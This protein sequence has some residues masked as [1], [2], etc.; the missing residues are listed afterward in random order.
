M[1]AITTWVLTLIISVIVLS[2]CKK[3]DI[4]YGNQ[5]TLQKIQHKWIFDKQI[6]VGTGTGNQYRDTTKGLTG[7]Y[8]D[9]RTDNKLYR[10]VSNY[11]D[12][13]YYTLAGDTQII[14]S[15]NYSVPDT[16]SIQ[17]LSESNFQFQSRRTFSGNTNEN[18]IYLKK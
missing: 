2:S 13:L 4:N 9:F 1:K 16:F 7:D 3:N 6:L 18:T 14:F 15:T 8:Y 10:K 5:T 11:N 12:T 17:V